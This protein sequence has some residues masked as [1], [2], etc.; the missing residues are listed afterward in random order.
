MMCANNSG[1][2]Y[3]RFIGGC[4]VVS[5]L[6][7]AAAW[8]SWGAETTAPTPV[9]GSLHVDGAR[10][11][12]ARGNTVL[13][14][15]VNHH[16]FVDVPD[17]GWDAPGQPLFS[18]MGHW[19]PAVVK[20]T[21]GDYHRLGFNVVRFHT[22]VEWW[23]ENPRSYKDPW[24]SVTYPEP[25]RQMLKDTIQWAGER[26]LYV[27]L[28]FF[29][30]KNTAGK[31]SGQESLP[32]PPYNRHPD[33]VGSRGEFVALWKSVA[34]DLGPLPNVLFELYNEPHGDEQA[35]AEWFAFCE[36][37]LAGIREF[38]RNPVIIQW[39]YQCWVNL[40]YPPPQHRAS[41]LAWVER[42][43]LKAEN[44]VYG[45]HLYRNS[46]GGGPGGVHRSKNGLVNLWEAGDVRQGLELS[47]FAHT[48]RDLQ[49]PLLVT[50][51][52]AYMAYK[53]KDREEQLGHEL[54]WFK[55]TLAALNDWGI[56]YV[57]WVWRSDEHLDHG[58]LHQGRPNQAGQAFLD[59][60]RPPANGG[61]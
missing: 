3:T 47:G 12:D 51:I 54:L 59:S 45:T 39:D 44:I 8:G 53:G 21:L 16:G 42:Y 36:E 24:R 37:A 30:M 4:A 60:L 43:P 7:T 34:H 31:Q 15:G 17:G 33:V 58:A 61:R 5:V 40:D 38:T 18:G 27:I 32:W 26:G 19:D 56:G 9:T 46:G 50:E 28:D 2:R 35:E 10:L 11:K 6:W 49:K 23:K 13:L 14:R 29:A 22:I 55:N 48:V 1:M 57:G 25:Y 20:G 52:G 41:T